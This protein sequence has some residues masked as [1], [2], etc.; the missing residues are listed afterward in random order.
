MVNGRGKPIVEIAEN[1][2]GQGQIR[3]LGGSEYPPGEK[4]PG[5]KQVVIASI[6]P[7][8]LLIADSKGRPLIQ[9]AG[10]DRGH[11]SI[12]LVNVERAKTMVLTGL[13]TSNNGAI[14]TLTPDG[15]KLVVIGT[16][17]VGAGL[18]STHDPAGKVNAQ[19]PLP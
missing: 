15:R 13:D 5:G 2:H 10:D 6:E 8:K 1:S 3:I 7:A 4:L 11:G 17:P 14:Q 9:L 18:V 16:S 19:L 12:A